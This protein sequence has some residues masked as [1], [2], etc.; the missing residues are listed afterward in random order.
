[1]L[2][3]ACARL[4][5]NAPFLSAAEGPAFQTSCFANVA[6]DVEK[7]TNIK[8]HEG[9]VSTSRKEELMQQRGCVLWFTGTP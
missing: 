8:W 6:Y 3:N 2:R 7:S 5:R 1:M 4:L 9:G